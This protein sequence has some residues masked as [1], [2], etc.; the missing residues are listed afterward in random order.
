MANERRAVWARSSYSYLLNPFTHF[1]NNFTKYFK[2]EYETRKDE[3]DGFLGG[4]GKG[5]GREECTER[6][7]ATSAIGWF[8]S[9]PF[10]PLGNRF[11][12]LSCSFSRTLHLS[13][14]L[15]LS[16]SFFPGVCVWLNI[17]A[18]NNAQGNNKEERTR[19]STHH[20]QDKRAWI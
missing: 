1:H 14:S 18:R 20:K 16:L 6:V 10:P 11:S 3:L 17:Y 9:V 7:T 8:M 15:S 19:K 13:A 5:R 12:C 4:W 2:C